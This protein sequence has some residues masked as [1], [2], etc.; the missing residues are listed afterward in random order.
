MRGTMKKYEIDGERLKK[1]IDL[2]GMSMAQA[3]LAIGRSSGYLKQVAISGYM[4]EPAEKAVEAILNIP[5]GMYLVTKPTEAPEGQ[6]RLNGLETPEDG[7][8]AWM[9]YDELNKCVFNAV[10]GALVKF[11]R[12]YGFER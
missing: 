1:A 10:Y 12:D 9:S 5:L 3:S 6:G 2:Q 7:P 8:T 4:P 11:D